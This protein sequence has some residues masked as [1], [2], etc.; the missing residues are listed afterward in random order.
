MSTQ[1]SQRF[2]TVTE[3]AGIVGVTPARIRQ[4]I[5]SGQ[6]RAQQIPP[7]PRGRWLIPV[8]EVR[9][10]ARQDRRPGRPSR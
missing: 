2:V 7:Q 10:V 1:L 3:A 6:V 4:M 8:A 9:R 5:E